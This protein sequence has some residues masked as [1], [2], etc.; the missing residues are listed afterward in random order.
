MSSAVLQALVDDL[1]QIF[2]DRLDAVVAYGQRR[3]GPQ[4]ILALVRTLG[5]DDL[6]ACASR[7]RGWHKAGVATPLVLTTVDFERS[8]DAFPIEYGEILASHH[9]LH[10]RDPFEGLSIRPEDLR[11]ACEVQ[12][13]SHLL[14]VREDYIEAAGRPSD[15]EALVRESAPGFVA[16]LRNLARLE[17]ASADVPVAVGAFAHQ[18]MGLDRHVVDDLIAFAE[19]DTFAA[20]DALRVFPDYLKNLERLVAFVDE[21]RPS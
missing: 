10:G 7:L 21:W 4:P 8:L 6:N 2:S 5:I 18:R 12:A 11:R 15:I 1:R 14:H 3:Q 17:N 9:V 13:K 20:V 19:G 16:L